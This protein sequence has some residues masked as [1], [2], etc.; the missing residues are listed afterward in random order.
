MLSL[1]QIR[2]YKIDGKRRKRECERT[3]LTLI[4]RLASQRSRFCLSDKNMNEKNPQVD[5]YLEDGCGRCKLYRTPQCKV[6]FWR[7]ELTLLRRIMLDCG[8]TEEL[9]WSQPVYSFEKKNIGLIT[10]FNDNCVISFFKGALLKDENK[11]LEKPG[12]DSQAVRF[13]KFT[14]VK[15]IID[16]E[17]VLKAYLAEAIK[18]EKSGEKV[19]LKDISERE[20][21]EELAAKFIE[22]PDLKKAFEALTP[23]RQRGYYIHFLQPKQTKTRVERIV[24]CMPKIFVGKGFQDR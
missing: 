11:I 17:L 1:N 9:K 12:E 13:V 22:N 14:D 20:I 5:V 23:G 24:K 6:N 10:A 8:L 2:Y 18:I 7:E 4:R 21:P 19:K 15:K 16:L 3:C